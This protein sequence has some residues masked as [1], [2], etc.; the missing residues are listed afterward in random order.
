MIEIFICFNLLPSLNI[1][2]VARRCS[3]Q[4]VF[5]EIW[6]NSQE[7]T[8]TRVSFLISC[9]PQAFK[10]SHFMYLALYRLMLLTYQASDFNNWEKWDILLYVFIIHNG[11]FSFELNFIPLGNS[12]SFIPGWKPHVNINFFIQG[13]DFISVT[14]KCTLCLFVSSK[15]RRPCTFFLANWLL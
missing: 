6:Q 9:R 4:K 11:R 2:A 15:T 1:E 5:L 14:C 8:C 10:R 12:T 7:T 13:W 3:V